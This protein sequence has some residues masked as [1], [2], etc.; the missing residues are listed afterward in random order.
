[1][2]AVSPTKLKRLLTMEMLLPFALKRRLSA[3]QLEDLVHRAAADKRFD[4]SAYND[5]FA[6]YGAIADSW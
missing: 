4:L 2:P 1:M 3:A 5:E 6:G